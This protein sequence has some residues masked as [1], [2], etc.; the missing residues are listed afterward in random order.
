MTP[1][2]RSTA[3]NNSVS[4]VNDSIT[5]QSL[6][7]KLSS[8]LKITNKTAED[9]KS[10]KQ[11]QKEM[12]KSIDKCNNQIAEIN[13]ALNKQNDIVKSLERKLIELENENTS[14][15]LKVMNL[16]SKIND[17]TRNDELGT[18]IKNANEDVYEEIIA[19]TNS[20]NSRRC[21]LVVFGLNEQDQKLSQQARQELDKTKILDILNTVLPEEDFGY[22]KTTRIGQ[23][24]MNKNRI[25]KITLA[26]DD[27][28]HNVLRNSYHLRNIQRFKEVSISQDRTPRQIEHYKKIKNQLM[29]RNNKGEN[30]K[31]K[32]VN[33]VPK[34]VPLN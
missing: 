30:C 32:Y 34:I 33:G 28:V 23:Y 15:N 5:L 24:N 9:I 2:T 29:E 22:I 13:I 10:L 20:R 25:I 21:N 31:I 26:S 11:E 7:V 14:L 8:L 18:D 17:Q 16:E 27:M 4:E 1:P 19:E 6:D 12:N 3:R